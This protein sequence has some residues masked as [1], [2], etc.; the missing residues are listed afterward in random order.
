MRYLHWFFAITFG[1]NGLFMLLVPET[2]F[3]TIP[4]VAASGP[5]NAH[6]VRD[7]GA[8]YLVCGLA[9]GWLLREPIR[10]WPAALGGC[11]FLM[12][13]GTIHISEVLFGAQSLSPLLGDL[14][15]VLVLPTLAL[16]SAWPRQGVSHA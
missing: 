4:G 1:F 6:F 12:F 14:P 10:A 13:H 11:L 8:A 5:F 15:A 3:S 16:W 9:F 2:W 7:V